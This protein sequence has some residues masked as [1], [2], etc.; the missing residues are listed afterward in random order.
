LRDAFHIATHQ[1]S[2]RGGDIAFEPIAPG[3]A[4]KTLFVMLRDGQIA[5]EGTAAE[6]RA[7]GDAYLRAFLS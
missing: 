2:Q 1:A 3:A 6:L 7:T 5:F 4:P